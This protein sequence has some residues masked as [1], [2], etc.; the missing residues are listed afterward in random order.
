MIL[1]ELVENIPLK[2]V[3]DVSLQKEVKGVYIGDLLS[4]VMGNGTEETLW[5]TVQRHLNVVAVAELVDFSAIVFVQDVY[6]EKDTIDK[7]TEL[8]IPLFYSSLTAY[9]LSKELMKAG[10]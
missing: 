4:F 3:N 6:P 9:D 7:A 5:L 1:K 10:L 8:G 2:F